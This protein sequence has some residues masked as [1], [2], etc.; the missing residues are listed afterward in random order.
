M[1]REIAAKLEPSLIK[2]ALQINVD[3]TRENCYVYAD[4]DKIYQVIR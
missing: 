2:K 1:V 4:K 3:F